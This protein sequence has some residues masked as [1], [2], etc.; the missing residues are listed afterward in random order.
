M[1]TVLT[2]SPLEAAEYIKR[3]GTAAFPT[4]TVYGLGADLLNEN[5]ISKI[6]EAKQRP[7]DNPMIA[8]ISNTGQIVVV[9]SEITANARKF[10]ETFFPGP[11]T[12][13]LPKSAGVPLLATA[14]LETIGVRMPRNET[15][16]AFLTACGMP[17]AAP[18][19]NISGRPSPTAWEAVYEDLNGRIDCILQSD[20]TEIGLESTVVDCTS[21]VPMILRPGAVS[22]EQLQAIIPETRFYENAHYEMPR[23]PGLKHEHYA[24]AAKVV[25]IGSALNIQSSESQ[26]FIGLDKPDVEFN[27]MKICASVEEYA[28][29]F[30]AFF[31]EC[32]SRNIETIFCQKVAETGLGIALMDR[33]KRAAAR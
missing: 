3:G 7:A 12:I 23:S 6:F 19:A 26:A 32:D 1:Q 11:L 15:A 5:A 27:L 30:F 31:R 25:L 22:L 14:G 8:H 29:A 10:I 17:V 9:A 33:L 18:S 20:V 13:I 16:Q 4:E 21:E 24:P 2:K 28:S